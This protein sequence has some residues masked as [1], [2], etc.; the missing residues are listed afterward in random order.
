MACAGA[1]HAHHAEHVTVPRNLVTEVP[2]EVPSKQASSV[3]IGSIALQGVRRAD[4]E[5]GVR[6]VVLGLG[7][8]G[9]LTAQII[10]D[11][12]CQV[13]GTDLRGPRV[14]LAERLGIDFG[15]HPDSE[16]DIEAVAWDVARCYC[17]PCAP[18]TIDTPETGVGRMSSDCH[19][20]NACGSTTGNRP[21]VSY[22]RVAR[23][24]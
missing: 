8:V 15:L 17:S 19:H 10:Q 3:A 12:G 13:I 14:E 22:R 7:L 23:R 2:R 4:P 24:V 20:G 5:I 18:A 6:F 16:D 11:D 1:Q 9:K 21:V